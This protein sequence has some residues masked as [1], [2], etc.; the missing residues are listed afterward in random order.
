MGDMKEQRHEAQRISQEIFNQVASTRE[1][2]QAHEVNIA[3]K[4]HTKE[5][6]SDLLTDKVN[7]IVEELRSMKNILSNSSRRR[8]ID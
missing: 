5:E 1:R 6:I 3:H 2:M 8:S 4:Y 7:P